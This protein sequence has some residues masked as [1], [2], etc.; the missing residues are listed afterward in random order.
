MNTHTEEEEILQF[1]KKNEIYNKSKKKNNKGKKCNAN[2]NYSYPNNK[3][4]HSFD[5][6]YI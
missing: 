1:W 2:K 6:F 5:L 3:Y 4:E